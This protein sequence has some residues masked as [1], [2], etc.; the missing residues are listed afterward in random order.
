[1]SLIFVICFTYGDHND[2]PYVPTQNKLGWLYKA[3]NYAV[4]TIQK[5]VKLIVV[6]FN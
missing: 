6:N 4:L 5:V 3:L 2:Y 1:M